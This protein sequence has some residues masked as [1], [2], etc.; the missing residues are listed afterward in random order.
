[1]Q[2]ILNDIQRVLDLI[3]R[4]ASE[5]GESVDSFLTEAGINHSSVT[6]L[7]R[8]MSQGQKVQGF[9][10]EFFIRLHY[11]YPDLNMACFFEENEPIKKRNLTKSNKTVEDVN[12]LDVLE[13]NTLLR[14]Q[15]IVSAKET[16]IQLLNDK[17]KLLEELLAQYRGVK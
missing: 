15:A 12:M 9:S 14:L 17:V 6:Q 10:F 4:I 13:K 3:P 8:R 7:K 5:Y 11:K 1:M 2:N 16:E